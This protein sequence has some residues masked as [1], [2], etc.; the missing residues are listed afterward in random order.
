MLTVNVGIAMNPV[1]PTKQTLWSKQFFGCAALVGGFIILQLVAGE[2]L[3]KMSHRTINRWDHLI[4]FT[5]PLLL[6][7]TGFGFRA[8]ER[9][10]NNQ[11]NQPPAPPTER[12]KRDSTGND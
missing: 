1:T 6:S 5:V 3:G 12:D 7:A 9:R 11:P 2:D 8:H 4:W 10:V